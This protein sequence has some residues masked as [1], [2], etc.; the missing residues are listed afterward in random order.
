MVPFPR[1]PA[2]LSAKTVLEGGL[3]RLETHFPVIIEIL[4]ALRNGTAKPGSPPTKL[5]PAPR[6]RPSRDEKYQTS[7]LSPRRPRAPRSPE[8]ERRAPLS[9]AFPA[10]TRPPGRV[11]RATKLGGHR[12]PPYRDPRPPR[13]PEREESPDPWDLSRADPPPRSVRPATKGALPLRTLRTATPETPSVPRA[14]GEPRSLGPLPRGPPPP[15]ASVARRDKVPDLDALPPETRDPLAPPSGGRAA[16]H[17]TFSARTRDPTRQDCF[18]RRVT[19]FGNPL[20]YYNR[21]IG[22]IKKGDCQTK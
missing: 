8:R 7:G 17:G 10:R 18:G 21:N 16:P 13:S 14:G 6:A 20:S 1:G 11:R 12:D 9:G 2:T 5:G 4:D 3:P 15:G 19:S 22:R